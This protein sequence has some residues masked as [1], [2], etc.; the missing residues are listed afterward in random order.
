MRCK[1]V[2]PARSRAKTRFDTFCAV[3]GLRNTI[4][5]GPGQKTLF[6]RRGAPRKVKFRSFLTY[7]A[8][9][10]AAHEANLNL[11]RTRH[12]Q[13]RFKQMRLDQGFIRASELDKSSLMT[14]PMRDELDKK[15]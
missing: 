10:Q 7:E 12:Q 9:K 5:W 4:Y 8:A 1:T 3:C 13:S 11:I 15:R 14:K 2:F 6:D